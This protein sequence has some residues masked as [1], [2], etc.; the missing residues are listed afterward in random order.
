MLSVNWTWVAGLLSAGVFIGDLLLHVLGSGRELPA[1][2]L[3]SM[4]HEHMQLMMA[5]RDFNSCD[6]ER[7][8]ALEAGNVFC[9][10]QCATEAEIRQLPVGR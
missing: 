5:D 10:S 9:T 1:Q 3:L 8:L 4:S 2:R 6:Y 7:L